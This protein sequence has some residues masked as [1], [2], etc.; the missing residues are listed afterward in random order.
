[1][2]QAAGGDTQ[3]H[4]SFPHQMYPLLTAALGGRSGLPLGHAA[5]LS[6]SRVTGDL[7]SVI[8]VLPAFG[9]CNFQVQ[10]P[11]MHVSGGMPWL[12]LHLRALVKESRR[13]SLR[14]IGRGMAGFRP[15]NCGVRCDLGQG[16]ARSWSSHGAG[17]R[18]MPTGS[19]ITRGAG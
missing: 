11:T 7:F 17:Y 3:G 5:V 12:H 16:R 1:M 15:V 13:S 2:P 14:T 8:G 6:G 19:F 9:I 4:S 18:G 10:M